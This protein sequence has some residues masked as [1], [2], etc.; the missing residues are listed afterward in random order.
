VLQPLGALT[1]S[2]LGPA[3]ERLNQLMPLAKPALVKACAAAAWDVGSRQVDWR[4]ASALRT[5]CTALDAP[6]P[7]MTQ[8]AIDAVH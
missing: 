7:P 2:S 8:A 6:M 3:L 1:P 5:L 4:A